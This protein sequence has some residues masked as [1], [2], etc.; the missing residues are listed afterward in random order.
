M[1]G[2]A[3]I[4]ETAKREK[5]GETEE[6]SRKVRKRKAAE[7]KGEENETEQN[8]KSIFLLQDAD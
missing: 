2:K 6:G 7:R 1:S 3:F 5:K 8:E 4:P